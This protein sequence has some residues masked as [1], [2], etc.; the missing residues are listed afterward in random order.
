MGII[1]VTL[2]LFVFAVTQ[3]LIGQLQLG[4][5]VPKQSLKGSRGSLLLISWLNICQRQAARWADTS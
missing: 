1:W 2:R 3:A 5:Y 4:R